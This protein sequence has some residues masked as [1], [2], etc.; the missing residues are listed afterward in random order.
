MKRTMKTTALLTTTIYIAVILC[1]LVNCQ[2][3]KSASASQ[4]QPE[5]NTGKTDD[6][7]NYYPEDADGQR[8]TVIYRDTFKNLN[9]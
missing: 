4:G 3:Q 6:S 8:E 5:V 9:N 7:E 1:F 2:K